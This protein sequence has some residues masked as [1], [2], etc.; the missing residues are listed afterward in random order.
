M[1]AGSAVVRSVSSQVPA[2]GR[3]PR[4]D[5]RRLPQPLRVERDEARLLA[6]MMLPERD[7]LALKLGHLRALVV[8]Q[9]D[10]GLLPVLEHVLRRRWERLG[11]RHVI[12]PAAVLER[13]VRVDVVRLPESAR[14][15]RHGPAADARLV[16]HDPGHH[17]DRG[18]G[19]ERTRSEER[20]AR[21]ARAPE[22]VRAEQKAAAPRAGRCRECRGRSPRRAAARAASRSALPRAGSGTPSR[23]RGSGRGSRGSCARRAT[24]GT[25]AV[26]RAS[27]RPGR[28][29]A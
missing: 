25:G 9:H 21:D 8:G 12:D 19:E 17:E 16:P 6:R 11:L 22:Q 7:H 15:G 13:R 1:Y 29:S 10:A 18:A 24:R 3:P 23:P 5:D 28:S 4:L 27:L 14:V 20:A 2:P 26:R